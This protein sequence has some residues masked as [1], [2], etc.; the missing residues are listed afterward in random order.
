LTFSFLI[1]SS[2]LQVQMMEKIQANK[3]PTKVIK[4]IV[5]AMHT[6]KKNLM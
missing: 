5:A 1:E 6:F 4:G 3:C 2:L